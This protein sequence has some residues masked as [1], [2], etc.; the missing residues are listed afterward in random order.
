MKKTL[1]CLL[2]GFIFASCSE[3]FDDQQICS[4]LWDCIYKGANKNPDK[5]CECD[6]TI[7]S[8]LDVV[9]AGNAFCVR[10][11]AYVSYYEDID[12]HLDTF[13]LLLPSYTDIENGYNDWYHIRGISQIHFNQGLG[14]GFR[15]IPWNHPKRYV[16]LPE[17][18]SISLD[19]FIFPDDGDDKILHFDTPNNLSE[20]SGY[21]LRFE[22]WLP[23]GQDGKEMHATMHY[24]LSEGSVPARE[25]ISFTM[26]KVTENVE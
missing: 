17:G 2:I 20:D 22:A 4:D 8:H 14:N 3:K 9:N 25:P 15:A 13:A 11:G 24:V 6:C 12:H 19:W 10:S 26:Y 18:D 5:N 16:R 1:F 21:R 23:G 7:W